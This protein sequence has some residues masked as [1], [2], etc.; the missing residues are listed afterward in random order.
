MVIVKM[1]TGA[2]T[3]ALLAERVRD[4][5]RVVVDPELGVDVVSL[6]LVYEVDV[7]AAGRARIVFSLTSMGCPLGAL[8]E[9]DL[10]AAAERVEGVEAVETELVF[11]PAW[12]PERMAGEVKFALGY[13]L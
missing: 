11:T 3:G 2:D 1:T 8:I 6:G 13:L 12:S 5:L 7:D 9:R 10:V 4:A